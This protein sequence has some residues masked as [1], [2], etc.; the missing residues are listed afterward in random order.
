MSI[1]LRFVLSICL[2]MLVNFFFLLAVL[3]ASME[4]GEALRSLGIIQGEKSD[5]VRF[6]HQLSLFVNDV[7]YCG[8]SIISSNFALTAGEWIC[9]EFQCCSK[10]MNF[11]SGISTSNN[12]LIAPSNE[13]LMKSPSALAL[14]SQAGEVSKSLC[15]A[16]PSTRST[17][18]QT[19]TTISVS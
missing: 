15:R 18:K 9:Y 16:K 10:T 1:K 4:T 19:M 12:Q 7:F 5:I 2:Q 13:T 14:L 17:T 6:P 8:A 11:E 3:Q